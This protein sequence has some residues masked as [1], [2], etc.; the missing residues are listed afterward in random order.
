MSTQARPAAG[1]PG[2]QSAPQSGIVWVASYP[3]SGNTWTR[4]FLHNLTK[5]R[6]G[7]K[8]EQDIN[9]LNRFSTW[10]LNKKHYAEVLGYTPRNDQ[11]NEIA[12]A[13]HRVH[14]FI[15]D[16]VDGMVFIKTHN[17]L[18]ID[19]GHS[20]VNFAVTA[21]AIYVV[22]NPLDVAIS[23]A[24]HMGCPID[25]AIREMAAE[26]VETPGNDKAVYEVHGSWTQHVW[27]WTRTPHRALYLMRYEDMLEDPERT[28][29]GLARHL[30]MEPTPEQ[31]RE[32]IE[33]SSFERLQAQEKQKGFRESSPKADAQFFR[34]GRAGQWKELLT[35]A[36]VERIVDVHGEQMRRFGYLPLE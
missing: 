29:G 30:L 31:L 8:G 33:R 19:R 32:A 6:S 28:F 20:T 13:R 4:T 36:Q 35:Q 21:G 12:A 27:S 9:A 10:D 26:N 24:H 2:I 17:A 34:E 18:V 16:S 3:K 11:R 23:Y 15:A 25:D 7:E 22:R 14:Q 1:E 5:I